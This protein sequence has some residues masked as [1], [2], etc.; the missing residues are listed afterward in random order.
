MQKSNDFYDV[1]ICQHNILLIEDDARIG[2]WISQKLNKL[3]NIG[4]LK[5]T[6]TLAESLEALDSQ[7]PDVVILDLKLPDGNGTDVLKKIR[8]ENLPVKVLV[9]S[10]NAGMKSVCRRLGAYRFFDKASDGEELIKY[11]SDFC[12]E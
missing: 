4:S 2:S 3:D 10:M 9:F 1:M 6:S 7:M 12:G 8:N 5:W 11:L